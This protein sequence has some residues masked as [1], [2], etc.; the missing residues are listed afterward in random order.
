M[1]FKN[2]QTFILVH[3]AWL[4]GWQW[5]EVSDILKKQGHSVITPDLPGHGNDRTIAQN[6]TMEDYVNTILEIIDNEDTQ[7]ILVG[8]SFNGITVSRVAELRPNSIK[9]LIF[10]AAFLVHKGESFNTVSKIMKGSKAVDNF[11]LSEDKK[12]ALIKEDEIHNAFAHDVSTL[13][14]NKVKPKLVPEPFTPLNYELEISNQ[15]FGKVHKY[16]IETIKDKAIPVYLQRKMYLGK[17]LKVYSIN[18]SHTPNFS[19]P[20]ELAN[21]LLEILNN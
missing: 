9:K 8:H 10:L 21:I 1:E 12:Y 6:I 19:K 4:G 20:G 13:N 2:R 18:S 7:V 5:K 11:Y 14:F 3:A 16:Y 17:V 15:N